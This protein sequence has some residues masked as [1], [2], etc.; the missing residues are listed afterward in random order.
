MLNSA[1]R[2]SCFRDLYS[3]KMQLLYL[4]NGQIQ[5]QIL[6]T[7][8]VTSSSPGSQSRV[9]PGLSPGSQ[10]IFSNGCYVY[11]SQC[12]GRTI[13]LLLSYHTLFSLCIFVVFILVK[14]FWVVYQMDF[15]FHLCFQLDKCLLQLLL[16]IYERL[17]NCASFSQC[18]R[19]VVEC[20]L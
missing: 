7:N 2:K 14:I 17:H 8:S 11:Q 5:S 12:I 18:L 4:H 10:S 6:I 15:G 3:Q 16:L 9:S 20:S 13:V 1:F 19:A